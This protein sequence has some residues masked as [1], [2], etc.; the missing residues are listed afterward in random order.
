MPTT[1]GTKGALT[2]HTHSHRGRQDLVALGFVVFQSPYCS[3]LFITVMFLIT[4]FL[5]V[6]V[7]ERVSALHID[8]IHSQPVVAVLEKWW[9]DKSDARLC[10]R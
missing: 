2:Q 5:W 1:P 8:C 10:T 4:S 7:C 6:R 3:I 9:R